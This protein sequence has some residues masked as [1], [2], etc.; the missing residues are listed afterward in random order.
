MDSEEACVLPWIVYTSMIRLLRYDHKTHQPR[1]VRKF[2][3]TT[4]RHKS[5]IAV[6]MSRSA[7]FDTL[8]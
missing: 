3:S 7:L 6:L 5:L 4:L 1:I 2:K 8:E